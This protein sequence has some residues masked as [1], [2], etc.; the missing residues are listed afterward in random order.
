[1]TFSISLLPVLDILGVT[2]KLVV[3]ELYFPDKLFD[4]VL[5]NLLVFDLNT[6]IADGLAITTNT[7][8]SIKTNNIA[9]PPITNGNIFFFLPFC[10][11]T[12]F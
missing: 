8:T 2:S 11:C 1:M 6:Y 3:T 4:N 10:S 5:L 7:I 12:T 9:I